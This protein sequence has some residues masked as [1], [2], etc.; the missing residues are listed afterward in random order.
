MH[1][2]DPAELAWVAWRGLAGLRCNASWAHVTLHSTS[3]LLRL[4][5]QS[6]S[7]VAQSVYLPEGSHPSHY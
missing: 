2:L 3:A 1:T 6:M 4:G 7:Q 5:T